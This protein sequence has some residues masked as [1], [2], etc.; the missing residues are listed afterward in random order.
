LSRV[1][2][3]GLGYVTERL[4]GCVFVPLIGRYGWGQ[5]GDDRR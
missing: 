5:H 4:E 2:R 3:S 1:R